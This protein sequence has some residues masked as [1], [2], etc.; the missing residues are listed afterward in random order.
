MAGIR[1]IRLTIS[2]F[3]TGWTSHPSTSL[4]GPLISGLPR[5]ISVTLVFVS[6][7]T[8]DGIGGCSSETERQLLTISPDVFIVDRYRC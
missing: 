6:A 7:G 4:W 3:W 8:L 1:A 5:G 2:L